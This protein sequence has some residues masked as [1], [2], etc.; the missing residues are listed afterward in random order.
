MDR[1]FD[2]LVTL[3]PYPNRISYIR[4]LRPYM[5][6]L[7]YLEESRDAGELDWRAIGGTWGIATSRLSE[8]RKSPDAFTPGYLDELI[9]CIAS[10]DAKSGRIL[11]NYVGKYFEDMW[12]HL[13]S[14]RRLMK[15]ACRCITSSA[16]R[17]FTTCWCPPNASTVTC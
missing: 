13:T 14:V 10:S 17:S 16:T 4:E 11:G 5:Y 9:G 8:W 1:E 12:Q 7:G 6:W 2:L 15:P 3:P